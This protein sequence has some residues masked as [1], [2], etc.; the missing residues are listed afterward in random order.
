MPSPIHTNTICQPRKTTNTPTKIHLHNSCPLSHRIRGMVA[1]SRKSA[2]GRSRSPSKRTS[3]RSPSPSK[4]ASN[5][6]TSLVKNPGTNNPPASSTSSGVFGVIVLVLLASTMAI[7]N[8]NI[9]GGLLS[10]G[11]SSV[12]WMGF[13]VRQVDS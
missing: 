3:A 8:S 11:K 1:Q 2:P 10:D 6:E 5:K 13:S 7:V 12:E 9:S 4:I